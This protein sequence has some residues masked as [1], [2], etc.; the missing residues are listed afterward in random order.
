MRMQSSQADCGPFS[1]MN[2]L[3]ALGHHRSSLELS[4][5]AKTTAQ[6][7][8]PPAN[9]LKACK[10]LAESCQLNP[11]R[12]RTRSSLEAEAVLLNKLRL[13][14]PVILLV[15]NDEHWV[16]AIGLLGATVVLV[17]DSAD[18]ELVCAA[19]IADVMTRWGCVNTTTKGTHTTYE[20]IVL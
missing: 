11:E 18:A 17:A 10:L 20:G 7:G 5:M 3:K 9:L 15:D 4:T 19:D 16:A 13:G 2:A 1:L 14:R 12:L 8:T 6:D